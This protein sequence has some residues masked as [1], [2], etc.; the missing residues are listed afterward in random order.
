MNVVLRNLNLCNRYEG[1]EQV[2]MVFIT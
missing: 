2:H 1:S